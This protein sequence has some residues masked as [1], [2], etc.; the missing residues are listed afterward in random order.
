MSKKVEKTII[1]LI[2]EL[3]VAPR[4]NTWIRI[5]CQLSFLQSILSGGAFQDI[6]AAGRIAKVEKLP[7]NKERARISALLRSALGK[8][9]RIDSVDG[10][11]ENRQSHEVVRQVASD[12]SRHLQSLLCAIRAVDL[13]HQLFQWIRDIF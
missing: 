4:K 3:S 7:S 13:A 11:S 6:A 9:R 10:R 5:C 12:P 8:I 2:E 1:G